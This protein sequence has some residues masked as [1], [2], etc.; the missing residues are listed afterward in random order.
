MSRTYIV[1]YVH[2]TNDLPPTSPRITESKLCPVCL[3]NVLSP[4][5][6]CNMEFTNKV[7]V[8]IKDIYASEPAPYRILKT[9]TI[10]IGIM[11][12]MLGNA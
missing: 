9:D 3:E 7:V 5:F 4:S 8:K 2:T 10:K 12:T 1:Q 11:F 6:L